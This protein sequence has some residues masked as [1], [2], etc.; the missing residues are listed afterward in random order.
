M[1]GHQVHKK[2]AIADAC[3]H[4]KVYI[5]NA[6]GRTYIQKRVANG[7]LR[8]MV[9]VTEAQARDHQQI[10]KTITRAIQQE[11]LDR[12]GA[13]RLR[14]PLWETGSTGRCGNGTSNRDTE[15]SV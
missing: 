14:I 11:N 5:T 6:T 10:I 4:R 12:D 1:S 9:Q 13:P 7:K 3:G 15:Q 8:F 2:P